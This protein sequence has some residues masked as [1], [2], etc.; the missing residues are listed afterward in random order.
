MNLQREQIAEEAFGQKV[1]L[2]RLYVEMVEAVCLELYSN[3]VDGVGHVCL[4]QCS[5]L[6]EKI[7]SIGF[8]GLSGGKW[9]QI[10]GM[11]D[12]YSPCVI[13]HLE[14]LIH[15]FGRY[16]SIS[17]A[18]DLQIC[19]EAFKTIDRGIP[20]DIFLRCLAETAVNQQLDASGI[21]MAEMRRLRSPLDRN[22][23]EESKKIV[24][25]LREKIGVLLRG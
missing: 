11:E 16:C 8:D 17:D 10:V 22:I 7:S 12:A 3:Q 6:I 21:G 18:A 23:L 5:T 2:E 9:K 13:D 15:S 25:L 19:V 24:S 4:P 14:A 20:V 1:D